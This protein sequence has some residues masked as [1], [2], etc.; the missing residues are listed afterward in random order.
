MVVC[1]RFCMSDVRACVY[2]HTA[3]I[4]PLAFQI[5]EEFVVVLDLL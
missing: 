2:T 1:L 4:Y 5:K 3:F